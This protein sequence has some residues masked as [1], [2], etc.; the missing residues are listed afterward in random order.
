[1]RGQASHS[2]TALCSFMPVPMNSPWEQLW[3]CAETVT[4]GF[5]VLMHVL[6]SVWLLRG[7]DL[8]MV[9][10][11][12]PPVCLVTRGFPKTGLPLDLTRQG[13][14]AVHRDQQS[15]SSSRQLS[16]LSSLEIMVEN[17]TGSY[18]EAEPPHCFRWMDSV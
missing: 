14:K 18:R 11:E 6:K 8:G 9:S 3:G 10:S 15:L 16:L 4:Q 17:T 5:S 12:F 1:M 13:K 7:V 2:P